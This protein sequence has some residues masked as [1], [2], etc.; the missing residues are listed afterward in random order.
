M[1]GSLDTKL[2]L[3]LIVSNSEKGGRSALHLTPRTTRSRWTFA[4]GTWSTI[5][6][7]CPSWRAASW[8]IS[9]STCVTRISPW[10]NVPRSRTS[11]SRSWRSNL[12]GCPAKVADPNRERI[13]RDTRGWL[14]IG[15][16]WVEVDFWY[17]FSKL[18]DLEAQ[19]RELREKLEALRKNQKK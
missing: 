16:V 2:E 18:Q 3:Q 9:I 6:W 1:G 17:R 5:G 13:W 12:Y 4:S 10:R 15:N 7:W 8:R 14:M 11:K 19:R